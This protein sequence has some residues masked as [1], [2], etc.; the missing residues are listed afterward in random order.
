M[1]KLPPYQVS[2]QAASA[3]QA[4]QS[5]NHFDSAFHAYAHIIVKR[6]FLV[7]SA[8]LAGIVLAFFLNLTQ[9]PVFEDRKSVV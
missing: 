6:K 4:H 5:D 7:F 9:Q 8:I 3:D 2:T 1:D